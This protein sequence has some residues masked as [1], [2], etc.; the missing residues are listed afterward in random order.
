MIT[1]SID[2]SGFGLY[3]DGNVYDS[4]KLNGL[5]G[6]IHTRLT[7][8]AEIKKMGADVLSCV[9]EAFRFEQTSQ[10]LGVHFETIA[11]HCP[12]WTLNFITGNEI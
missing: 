7:S 9:T 3:S 1:I 2:P 10:K 4:L 6:R 8:S 11:A 12:S 5:K